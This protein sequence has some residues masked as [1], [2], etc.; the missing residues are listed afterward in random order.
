MNKK[1]IKDLIR[2]VYEEVTNEEVYEAAKKSKPAKTSKR[3]HKKDVA[4][5]EPTHKVTPTFLKTIEKRTKANKD[6]GEKPDVDVL[7]RVHAMLKNRVGQT[8][9]ESNIDEMMEQIQC[10]ECW[11]EGIYNEKLDA[12]GHEDGDINNDGRVDKSDKYLKHRRAAIGAAL[13]KAKRLKK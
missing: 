11:E 10:E 8:L 13:D 9:E 3:S 1:Y 6:R 7:S 4:S 2:E 12:V 5:E